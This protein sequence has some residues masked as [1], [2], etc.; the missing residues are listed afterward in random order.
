M[1]DKYISV[2]DYQPLLVEKAYKSQPSLRQII[3][4]YYVSRGNELD[5][6]C[7]LAENYIYEI[8]LNY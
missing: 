6:A 2:W 3:L 7:R 4:H 5:E 8:D 1:E